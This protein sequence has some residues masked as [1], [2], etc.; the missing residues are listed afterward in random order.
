LNGIEL[1]QSYVTGVLDGTILVCRAVRQSVERHVK[2]IERQNTEGF[3][4]V[5]NEDLAAFA[6]DAFPVLF[7][8]T[9]GKHLDK[10]FILTPWQAFIVGS[11]FGWIDS[12]EIRRFRKVYVS[13]ARKQGKSTLAAGIA[14]LLAAFDGEAQSQVYIGATKVDQAKIVFNEAERMVK[15][16][17]ILSKRFDC[18][19][20]QLNHSESNSFIRPL[21]SDRAFDGLN[22]HA[23]ILDELHAWRE[24]HRPFY[25]TI[26]TGSAARSQPVMFTITTAGD[27]L[28]TMWKE[29]N[30][31]ALDVAGGRIT[32]D[33]VFSFVASLDSEDD[34]FD[35]SVWPKAMPNIGVSVQPEYFRQ[36]A[37]KA[38]ESN[39]ERNVFTRYYANREVS[40]N[41][42]AI[43]PAYW[44]E[45]R[46]SALSDWRRASAIC[47]AVD[48]GGVSDL[49]AY[50]LV[51]RFPD[52]ID[53]KKR[54]IWRYEI[55]TR[56]YIDVDNNRNL[57]ETPWIDWIRNGHLQVV[58]DLY[59]RVREDLISDM[60]L[61]K[62]KQVGFDPWNMQQMAEELAR[63]G[64]EPIRIQQSRYTMH[65]PTSMMLDMIRKRKFTHDG[66][67]PMFRWCL[68]NL[69]LSVD[70]NNRW[71]PDKKKSG[72]KID[73]V[74]AGIMA[75][76]CCSLAPA[77]ARGSLFVA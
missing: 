25:N 43:D 26:R 23:V 65:E 42:Q 36:E 28:S 2:D 32:D 73:P 46:V 69:V 10:P 71:M 7:R 45:C 59:S 12:K 60:R 57:N 3:E 13:V 52:G 40:S 54:P 21:G 35:E 38:K 11:V 49:M 55:K 64:Y 58:S 24:H 4:F 8:H 63:A 61:H 37:I 14:I 5:F 22:P 66:S 67:Q 27:N 30:Q 56:C 51:A 75:L 31:Y 29:E 53:D 34:I 9:I 48:A 77:R 72:E 18:R 62:V 68:G 33:A 74:V 1:F 76:R 47:A 6:I 50:A 70:A 39:Q 44:D 17:P 16:S 20:N 15:R 19:V 41:E